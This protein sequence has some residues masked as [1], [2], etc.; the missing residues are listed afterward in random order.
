MRAIGPFCL[1][2]LCLPLLMGAEVYRW[3]DKDGVVNY[4]QVKPRDAKAII[5]EHVLDGQ[6]IER[7]LYRSPITNAIAE[8]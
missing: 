4:T 7:L 2:A 5:E 6:R 3:V 1:L 8:T